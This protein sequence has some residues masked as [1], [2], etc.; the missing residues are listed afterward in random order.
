MEFQLQD[1]SL[2]VLVCIVWRQAAEQTHALKRHSNPGLPSIN[3]LERP[4]APTAPGP[5]LAGQSS[6]CSR[7]VFNESIVAGGQFFLF[8][9]FLCPNVKYLVLYRSGAPSEPDLESRSF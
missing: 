5:G 6:Q 7:L 8:V 2:V 3:T 4:S 9:V 1:F